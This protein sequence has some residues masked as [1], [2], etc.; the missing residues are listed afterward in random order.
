MPITGTFY[1]SEEIQQLLGV[2][3][4]RVSDLARTY[5]W[6]KPYPG[7]YLAGPAEDSTTV[8]AYLFAR[9]RAD[10]RGEKRPIWDDSYDMDCPECGALAVEIGEGWK[11]INGH[12]A[13][14]PA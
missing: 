14:P 11:C 6:E 3:R 5:Q 1:T 8:S 4:Q 13:A 12:T 9:R 7:L 2:S 10:I